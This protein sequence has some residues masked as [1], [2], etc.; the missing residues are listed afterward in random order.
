VLILTDALI[1]QL[2]FSGEILANSWHA[3]GPV[4]TGA[5]VKTG[6]VRPDVSTPVALKAVLQAAKGIYFPDPVKSTAGIH[7]VQVLQQLGLRDELAD[8]LRPF[9]N[10]AT[11][12]KAT[13]D[14][15]ESGLLGCTQITEILYTEGAELVAL[16]PIE[17]ER[18]TVYTAGVCARSAGPELAAQ[19]IEQLA[20]PRAA[21]LR[22]ACSFE[23]GC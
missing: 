21:T 19:L 6:E 11:A 12:M 17:F 3:L 14:S 10:G 7:F 22:S 23:T 20:G 18:A 5:T 9:P 1:T 8:R 2:V 4:K 13:A 15:L 16:L